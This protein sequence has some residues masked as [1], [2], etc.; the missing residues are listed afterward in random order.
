MSSGMLRHQPFPTCQRMCS[1][2]S[3]CMFT[4][5]TKRGASRDR[6]GDAVLRLSVL[7]WLVIG[8]F[9]ADA[10]TSGAPSRQPASSGDVA[11]SSGSARFSKWQS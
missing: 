4:L 3:F 2:P 5:A 8:T 9:R 1:R 10:H 6:G 11:W 7:I